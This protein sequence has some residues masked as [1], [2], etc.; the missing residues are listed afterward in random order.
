MQLCARI[1]EAVL[2][3][4]FRPELLLS[5]FGFEWKFPWLERF[6]LSKS[7]QARDIVGAMPLKAKFDP[8]AENLVIT[9]LTQFSKALSCA[10]I[11]TAWP[12]LKVRR[13]RCQSMQFEFAALR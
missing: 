8:S 5:P 9:L 1:R 10:R 6:N 13:D 2:A 7:K 4:F 3:I 12:V 11:N